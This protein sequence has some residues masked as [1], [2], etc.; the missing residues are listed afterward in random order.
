M[1]TLPILDAERPVA[2][3]VGHHDPNAV[4]RALRLAPYLPPNSLYLTASADVQ[5]RLDAAALPTQTIGVA[6]SS[7]IAGGPATRPEQLLHNWAAHHRSTL[8]LCDAPFEYATSVRALPN[9]VRVRRPGYEAEDR[10]YR[11]YGNATWVLSPYASWLESDQV[12]A[13]LRAKTYYTGCL[14]DPAHRPGERAAARK[15]CGFAPD[16][17]YIVLLKAGRHGSFSLPQLTRAA[18]HVPQYEWVRLGPVAHTRDPLPANLHQVGMVPDPHTYLRA[19]DFIVSD[20]DE[21]VVH[22]VAACGAP[23]VCIPE[24]DARHAQHTHAHAL[25]KRGMALSYDTFPQAFEWPGILRRAAKLSS[26]GWA[27]FYCSDPKQRIYEFLRQ[28]QQP[29]IRQNSVSRAS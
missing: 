24:P 14:P 17:Q 9:L 16:K 18:Q 2:Y 7:S 19:A 26:M 11:Q 1:R 29:D 13:W 6:N 4:S 21:G 12:P 5:E 10:L 20:A 15:A 3:Y 8:T 25:R 27:G 28:F 22:R 23:L